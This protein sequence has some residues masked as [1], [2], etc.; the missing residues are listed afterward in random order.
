MKHHRCHGSKLISPRC[1]FTLLAPCLP[2]YRRR[3]R[4]CG[5]HEEEM[6]VAV[7]K[8]RTETLVLLCVPDQERGSTG[9]REPLSHEL[10]ALNCANSQG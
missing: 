6:V 8:V 4:P 7:S 3:G 5:E 1:L 2:S 10:Q 9:G